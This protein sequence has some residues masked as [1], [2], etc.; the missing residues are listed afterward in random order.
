MRYF[1]EEKGA[2]TPCIIYQ[3]TDYGQEVF[4]G[5]RQQ[6]AD[7]GLAAIAVSAHKPT[8]TEFTPAILRLRN[9]DCDLVLM[10]TV[11]KDTILI[12]EAAR[13]LGWDDVSWVG[14]NASYSKAVA[15]IDSGASEGYSVFTHITVGCRPRWQ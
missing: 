13:K 2:T 5:A 14:T 4:D 3:D 1:V 12:F 6:L 8:D 9:A 11:H 10:G 15:D 7:M